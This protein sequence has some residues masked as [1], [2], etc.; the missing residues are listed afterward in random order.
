MQFSP[1]KI[2]CDIDPEGIKLIGDE[3]EIYVPLNQVSRVE[4]DNLAPGRGSPILNLCIHLLESKENVERF[5]SSLQIFVAPA[6][7][8]ENPPQTSADEMYDM[9]EVIEALKANREPEV[10]PNPYYRELARRRKLADFSEEKYDALSLPHTHTPVTTVWRYLFT[11]V[12]G[13][14]GAFLLIMLLAA[15]IFNLFFRS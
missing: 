1:I 9:V 3:K 8:F 12:F 10:H 4:V 11:N 6:R 14:I 13:V 5:S 15:L 7:L 2:R